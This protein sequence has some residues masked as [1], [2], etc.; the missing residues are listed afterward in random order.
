[1]CECGHARYD[2]AGQSSNKHCYECGHRELLD[3]TVEFYC[4]KFKRERA[5]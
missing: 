5:K 3:G 1:M 4:S 2:H